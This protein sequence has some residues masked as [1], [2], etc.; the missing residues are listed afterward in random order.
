MLVYLGNQHCIPSADELTQGGEASI[1]AVSPQASWGLMQQ[2]LRLP[3]RGPVPQ[4]GGLVWGRCS[5]TPSPACRGG[6]PLQQ[7]LASLDD[8]RLNG[9]PAGG[10]SVV[11]RWC[12]VVAGRVQGIGVEI[13]GGG[14][15]FAG[16][17]LGGARGG[18]VAAEG[19]WEQGAATG[20]G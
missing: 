3:R 17:D 18:A 6:E 12:S 11:G 5:R 1:D 10:R 9:S 14:S 20:G 2:R 19:I 7:F 16:G 15:D 8:G 13:C 4:L